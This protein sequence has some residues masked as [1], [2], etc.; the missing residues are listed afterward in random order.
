MK[1][2]LL[3]LLATLLAGACAHN[4]LSTEDRLALFRA[5]AGEPVEH[6]QYSRNLRW[7][8][9]GDQALAVWPGRNQGY[10]LELRARCPDLNFANAIQ[11]TNSM[12]RV[13]A[14]FDSVIVLSRPGGSNSMRVPCRIQTIQPLDMDGLRS[15]KYEM[16]EAQSAERA[17]GTTE[18]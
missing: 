16:R 6:F 4:T 12:N 17:P 2:L 15:D 11:I 14:R 8:P 9:L 3:L 18:E 13:N 5:N 7:T 10:L 1:K